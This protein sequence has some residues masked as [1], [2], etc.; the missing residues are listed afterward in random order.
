MGRSV[1]MAGIDSLFC[2]GIHLLNT[3]CLRYMI[4]VPSTGSPMIYK[5]IC[6]W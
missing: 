3:L 1:Y 5:I 6:Q 2:A 4:P